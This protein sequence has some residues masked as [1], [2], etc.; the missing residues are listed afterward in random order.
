MTR[1]SELAPFRQVLADQLSDPAL[2]A[3][4][5]RT[6]IGRFVAIR[7]L[8]YRVKIGITQTLSRRSG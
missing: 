3:E 4:W 7:L 5:E 2:R 6:S 8:Q 1:L